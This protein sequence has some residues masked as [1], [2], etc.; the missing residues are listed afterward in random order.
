MLDI[1][2]NHFHDPGFSVFAKE[3]ALNKGIKYLDISKNKDLSDE[4]S[5]VDLADCI[6]VN[7]TLRS[8]DLSGI[9]LRKPFV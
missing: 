4:V 2:R 7:T 5:L 6:A 8:L 9:R 3:L 1:S